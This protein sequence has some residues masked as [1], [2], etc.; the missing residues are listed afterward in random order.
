MK[1]KSTLAFVLLFG[2]LQSQPCDPNTNSLFFDGANSYVAFGPDTDLDLTEEITVEAWIKATSWGS[3][4]AVN[5]IVC[6]HGW[7]SGE[8]GFVLR[9][10]A[11]G[12]LSFTI[13]GVKSDGTNDSWKEVISAAGALQL[14]T[15]HH[16]AGTFSGTKLRIYI[17]GNQ[18]G[19]RNFTGTIA[20]SSDYNLKIGRIADESTASKRFFS[21]WIDEVRI[22]DNARS[23]SDLDDDRNEHINP[24]SNDLVAYWRF[25]EGTATTINDLGPANSTGT[26]YNVTWDI[27][28]PFTNGITRPEIS[29]F[30]NV[31]YSNSLFGNQWNLNGVPISG[32]NG[33]SL[34]PMHTGIYTLTVNYGFG[35]IATSLPFHI[36]I[37]DIPQNESEIA[38]NYYI[39]EGIVFFND[40]RNISDEVQLRVTDI[41]GR[42]VRQEA[43]IPSQLNLQT[44][45]KG[46]YI[47]SVR[48]S[49]DSFSRK[50]LLD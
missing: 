35:C 32:E 36:L 40:N 2:T 43:R 27:D 22:W 14:N 6:K 48:S 19:S 17:D 3:S 33:V 29:E 4:P 39:Q 37:T 9:T 13:A 23:G 44:L 18:V 30:S 12:Q 41:Q 20:N 31:L 11:N 15:W 47:M 34:T 45:P 10:G 24:N 21:G 1:I 46:I 26:I 42:L 5:S 7:T 28:V 25:N 8:K 16:V 38:F 50:I 49:T